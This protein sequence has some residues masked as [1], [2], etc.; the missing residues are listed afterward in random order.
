MTPSKEKALHAKHPHLWGMAM[1]IKY[2]QAAHDGR[3]K[4]IVGL[5]DDQDRKILA[6]HRAEL[7]R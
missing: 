7:R 2:L 5:L 3:Y 1:A 4:A 6:E